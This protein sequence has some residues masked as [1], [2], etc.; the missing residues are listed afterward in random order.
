MSNF[1]FFKS[2]LRG[3]RKYFRKPVIRVLE[4]RN[5]MLERHPDAWAYYEPDERTMYILREHDNIAVR[6]HEYGHWINACIYFILEIAWE[7]PWWCL[8]FRALVKNKGSKIR[9]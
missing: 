6:L 9:R 2:L 4:R 5:E 8:G 1:E 3:Y 7:F